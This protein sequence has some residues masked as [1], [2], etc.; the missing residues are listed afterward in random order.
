M[1]AIEY[2]KQN[3]D[4]LK[5]VFDGIIIDSTDP[6]IGISAG[7]F[8]KEFYANVQ[9]MMKKGAMLSQQCDTN[10][11]WLS[12]LMPVFKMTNLQFIEVVK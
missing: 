1:D 3:K 7:L 4:K 12:N 8:S 11:K 6:S 5:G 10:A 2:V 9:Q